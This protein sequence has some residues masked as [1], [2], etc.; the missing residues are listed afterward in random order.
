MPLMILSILLLLAL[1]IAI[2]AV[3]CPFY[4]EEQSFLILF[5]L[6]GM[7]MGCIIYPVNVFWIYWWD[8]V[9]F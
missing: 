9:L 5:V 4:Q 7:Y 6:L 2:L 8:S 1:N 3:F